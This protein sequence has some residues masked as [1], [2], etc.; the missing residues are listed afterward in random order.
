MVEQYPDKGTRG[1]AGGTDAQG[2]AGAAAE[3]NDRCGGN[4]TPGLNKIRVGESQR[5][6]AT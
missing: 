3:G 5:V 2:I 1:T 4:P 6:A